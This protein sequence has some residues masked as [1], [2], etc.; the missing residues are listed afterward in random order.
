MLDPLY[1]KPMLIKSSLTVIFLVMFS[2]T[3]SAMSATTCMEA[4]LAAI[5]GLL[6]GMDK[7]S[8]NTINEPFYIEITTGVDDGGNYEAQ[9]YHYTNYDI[10]I[11]RDF[12]D[13]IVITSPELLWAQKIKIDA[14]RN[15]VEKHLVLEPVV[16]DKESSQYV[17]CSSVGDVYAILRYLNNK[18][19][20]IKLV[21][22][23]P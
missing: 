5:S 23:R 11:V 8:L 15:I 12:I 14:D 16:N 7:S 1:G 13:S 6:P 19:E 18:I 21:I 4:S 3:A 22:D 17:V 9:I 20:S 10:T 2:N